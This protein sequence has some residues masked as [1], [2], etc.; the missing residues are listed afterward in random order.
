M[1]NLAP[2]VESSE[3]TPTTA[4]PDTERPSV[5]ATISN[6]DVVDWYRGTITLSTEA[7]AQVTVNG[8]QVDLDLGGSVTLPVVNAPG[9]N[10]ILIRAT[11]NVG[12]TTEESIVYTF[13]APEGWIAA[14]GDSIMLGTKE[15]IEK[16]L[17]DGIVDATVSRQFLNAPSA[18][19]DLVDSENPPQA[20][21]IGLG[22]NGP[23]Q[24]RHFDQVME[25]VGPETL[26]AFINVRV[27]RDWEA[28][29]NDEIAAGVARYDNA[30]L[31]DWISAADDHDDLFAGDGFHPSQAGRVVLADL[32][33]R[34]ILPN[35]E[36]AASQ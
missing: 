33:A 6:D 16:R 18:V 21:V 30:I 28:T 32:I 2:I 22:T 13:D 9:E 20:V 5:E 23:V 24:A 31:V 34:A 35:W 1:T 11:D 7:D 15:E 14:I 3:S 8:E 25:T 36:S 17:G 19:G 27:P 10:T 29:S 4:P 12:N 26:V